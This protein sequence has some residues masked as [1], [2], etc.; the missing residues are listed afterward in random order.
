MIINLI[1]NS[2]GQILEIEVRLKLDL[3]ESNFISCVD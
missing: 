2:T 1:T 3:K